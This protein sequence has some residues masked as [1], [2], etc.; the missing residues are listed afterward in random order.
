MMLI[1][2]TGGI[3]A[4]KS[5]IAAR[6][7]ELGAQVV[8]ADQVAR[9]VVAPGQPALEAIERV[10]G[11]SV[12]ADDGSL[13]RASLASI[14]FADSG[15]LQQLNDIVHPAVR[16]ETSARFEAISAADPSAIIVYDV[17][18]LVESQNSYAFDHIVVAHAPVDVRIDRLVSLRGMSFEDAQ[19]R[20]AKQSSDEDRLAIA[21]TVIET[22]GTLEST[23]ASVDKFWASLQ[24][25]GA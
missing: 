17:P 25:P 9:D 6:L 19:N 5:T 13:D 1:G 11:A 18:L 23:M 2:L 20:V 14:V 8:D 4:G 7:R 24:K 10:F 3:G 12:I 22:G 15:K 21:D 16:A